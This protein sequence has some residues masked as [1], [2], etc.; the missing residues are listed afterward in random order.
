MIATLDTPPQDLARWF[1]DV[2]LL[3]SASAPGIRIQLARSGDEWHIVSCEPMIGSF[4]EYRVLSS[5]EGFYVKE[6][7]RAGRNSHHLH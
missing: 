1:E 5:V 7:S 4:V 2:S 3:L 6:I